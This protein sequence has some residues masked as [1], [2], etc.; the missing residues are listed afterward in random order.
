MSPDTCFSK[1]GEKK[2]QRAENSVNNV[3]WVVEQSGAR[4]GSCL[5]VRE[6][7]EPQTQEGRFPVSRGVGTGKA[8][9]CKNG[10]LQCVAS[11]L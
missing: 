10:L 6:D 1:K 5:S 8:E 9:N 4:N 2:I 3:F 7:R 11:D